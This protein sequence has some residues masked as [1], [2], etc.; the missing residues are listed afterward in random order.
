MS[1]EG[2]SMKR[3]LAACVAGLLIIGSLAACGESGGGN[4]AVL[5]V[6][7]DRSAL[8]LTVGGSPTTLVATVSPADA[9]DKSVTWSSSNTSVATVSATGVV[10]PVSA[11]TATITVT[12]VDGGLTASCAVT[13]ASGVVAVTGVSLDMTT[14]N[15]FVG[16]SSSTVVPTVSPSNATD[17]TV[18]WSSSNTGVATVS[19]SGVVTPVAAGTA[20]ITVTT[21]SGSFTDTVEVT[22]SPVA[23]TGVTLNASTMGL[24]LPGGTGMLVAM[25]A[26]GNATNPGVTWSSSD[27]GVA[28]VSNSGLVSGVAV[29]T[30]TITV[31]TTDGSFTDTCEVTVTQAPTGVSVAPE[32]QNLF[33]GGPTGMLTATVTPPAASQEVEWV[34]DHPEFVTVSATGVVT[35]VALGT[36]TITATA[37]GGAHTDTAQVTVI[38]A[39]VT[40]VSLNTSTLTKGVGDGDS[41]LVATVAPAYAGNQNVT[42]MSSN[43]AVATVS[44]SGV[45][46]AVAPGMATITVTTVDGSHTATCVVTVVTPSTTTLARW[47]FNDVSLGAADG[48]AVPD[49]D[50]HAV[51]RVAALDTTGNGNHLTTWEHP[52]AGF[53]WSN[54]SDQ[55]DFSILSQGGFPAAFT[56][57]AQSMPSGANIETFTGVSFT[58]EALATIANDGAYRTVVGRDAR[59][60]STS[61][62]NLAALYL[63]VLNNNRAVFRY[64]DVSGTTIEVSSTNTYAASGTVF[65]H[66]VGTTDGSTVSLYVDGILVG[67]ATGQTLGGLGIGP[68]STDPASWTAGGWTVGRGLYGGGHGDRWNGYIDAAAISNVMLTPSSFVLRSY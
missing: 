62:G 58:V 42:W 17:P 7:L 24:V 22:V 55:G 33:L 61:D 29:G 39:P 34:S 14:L 8:S 16:G 23:V 31:T 66:F 30:A 20:T 67:Q 49:S 63:G 13:V 10:A 46:H 50:Q 36:A 68:V 56:W 53:N 19:D 43:T 1:F 2:K 32:T 15:L 37:M 57:S 48:A 65:H 6:T 35:P 51:W 5:G 44:S 28:T 11:G 3:T 54:V 12:T 40:G 60:L 41:R 9:T 4:V 45:V 59:G 21:T 26:P 27:T 47:D 38:S 52:W 18:T 25:V 64:T